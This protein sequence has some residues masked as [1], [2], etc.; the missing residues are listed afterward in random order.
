MFELRGPSYSLSLG[1]YQGLPPGSEST[2]EISP[3]SLLEKW[4]FLSAPVAK[5]LWEHPCRAL[6]I[7]PPPQ[8]RLSILFSSHVPALGQFGFVWGPDQHCSSPG[9]CVGRQDGC[10]QL[11]FASQN[12]AWGWRGHACVLACKV[13]Q[14]AVQAKNGLH[15]PS[16]A[17]RS[18]GCAVG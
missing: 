15:T 14:G 7:L 1:V 16:C 17:P 11:H 3:V 10:L 5:I 13:L 6:R 8:K 2:T 12:R 18:L 4:V 9:L